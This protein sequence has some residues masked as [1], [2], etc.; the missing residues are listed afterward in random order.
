MS[1]QTIIKYIDNFIQER[2]RFGT[3]TTNNAKLV[4][5]LQNYIIT[6]QNRYYTQETI[7]RYWR[8]YKLLYKNKF[9]VEINEYFVQNVDSCK[10]YSIRRKENV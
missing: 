3:Y 8:K 6:Y 7:G 9:N 5:A 2:I 1:K 4:T 10:R